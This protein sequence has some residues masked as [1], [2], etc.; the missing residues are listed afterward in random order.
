[1]TNTLYC[2]FC[3]GKGKYQGMGMIEKKCDHCN[4]VGYVE[5]GSKLEE[6]PKTQYTVEGAEVI[7][8][9]K[10]QAKEA[11][12]NDKIVI[13]EEDVHEDIASALTS[14]CQKAGILDEKGNL[15]ET[16][17]VELIASKRRGRPP[18]TEK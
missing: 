11:I 1:M 9:T 6:K 3:I 14:I 4:G 16:V 13:S 5:A 2:P 17:P 8:L 15:A 10:E 18:R 12:A 7:V